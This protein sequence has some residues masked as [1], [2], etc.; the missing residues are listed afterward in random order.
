M[1]TVIVQYVTPDQTVYFL[2]TTAVM[3]GIIG[4]IAYKFIGGIWRNIFLIWLLA[5]YAV[6]VALT[7]VTVY[8]PPYGNNTIVETTTYNGTYF[9]SVPYAYLN[10]QTAIASAII[11]IAM[12]YTIITVISKYLR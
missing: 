6:I 5:I 3:L 2:V 11:I 7:S 10:V 8:L 12:T 4:F 1:G 9:Y